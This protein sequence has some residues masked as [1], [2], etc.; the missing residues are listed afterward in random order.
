MDDSK[1]IRSETEYINKS[2]L[3]RGSYLLKFK[4]VSFSLWRW[5]AV[6]GDDP[7]NA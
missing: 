5:Q 2:K 1:Q 6:G 4:K 3:I 7:V